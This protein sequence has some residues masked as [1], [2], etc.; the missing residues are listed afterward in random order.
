MTA[1]R[2]TVIAGGGTG[3]HIVPSLQIARAMVA[4][5]HAPAT[6]ELYGSHR[7]QEATTWP[8]LEFPYTLLPGRGIR[9][10]LLPEALWANAGAVAGLFWACLRAL[11]SFVARRPRVVVLVGG[12]ASFPAGVA[13]VVTRVPLVSV[14]TDAVAG[15]VNRLLGP[16]AAANAVAFE[17]TGLPRAHLTGT[18]VRPE[19]AA[20]D[21]STEG[22]A[23]GRGSLGL[24]LGRET[25]AAMGGSLGAL[26]INR[27]VAGL[28][29]DWA[30]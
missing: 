18:P 16:F 8:T 28:M 21:R 10:S 30:G 22:R 11:G 14:N 29:E 3:G 20:L 2:G 15:A 23:R 17:D 24:P 12:Y 13:A 19:L 4:R 27:A 26:R 1:R 25:V 7:G 6:V 5:G 9:R